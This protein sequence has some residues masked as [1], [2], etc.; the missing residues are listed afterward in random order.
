[1]DCCN[2]VVCQYMNP[3]VGCI[4]G[5]VSHNGGSGFESREPCRASL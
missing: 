4:C 1:M 2:G 5:K 3:V